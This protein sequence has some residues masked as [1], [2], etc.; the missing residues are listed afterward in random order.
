[1]R[2]RLRDRLSATVAAVVIIA[3]AAT[4]VTA[5]LAS[6]QRSR[7]RGTATAHAAASKAVASTFVG[8]DI[9]GP[10]VDRAS[11]LNLPAQ[12]DQMVANG[13][14][15]V[16]FA[17]NWAAAQP[18]PSWTDVPA[19]QAGEFTHTGTV[20][21]NFNQTDQLV[22]LAAQ[23]GMTVLPTVLY[24]PGW[25]AVDNSSNGVDYPA[26]PQP[27]ADYLTALIGRY[28]PNGTYWTSH[29]K[30]PKLPI[31]MWQ[32]WNEE[33]ISYY[34]AQP[35]AS[36]YVA[37]LSAAHAAIKKADPGA[38]VVLGALTNYAWISLGKIL[39]QPGARGLFDIASVNGFTKLP[40]DVI[41]YLHLVRRA[42]DAARLGRMPLLAT[43]VSWPSAVGQTKTNFDFDTTQAGQAKNI[44]ALLP[45][46][47]SNRRSLRLL[48]FYWYTWMG[49]EQRGAPDFSFAGLVRLT[50]FSQVI[51]KPALGA[52]RRGVLALEHCARKSSNA[53][54]CAK[55]A[56]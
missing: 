39:A 17:F 3:L 28:G 15:S 9:D 24:A 51:A 49:L 12:F 37:L 33:N 52:F 41:L 36:S 27:Y 13:V 44:T 29:P 45:M 50:P 2:N 26:Q 31:R 1:M 7:S 4:M 42:L 34:W 32:I 19:G 54:R 8:V 14:G 11:G 38:K 46:L 35:F 20:P 53:R 10:I 55:P 16:R 5:A 18:Y 25:D 30:I 21:T 48:A 23:H 43:E 40:R 56:S 6:A 22:G 47:G